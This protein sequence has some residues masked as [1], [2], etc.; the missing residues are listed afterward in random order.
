MSHACFSNIIFD[1]FLGSTEGRNE[2]HFETSIKQLILPQNYKMNT[3]ELRLHAFKLSFI[4]F[5]LLHP[6]NIINK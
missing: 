5:L 3:A 1:K 6:A 2:N 4:I